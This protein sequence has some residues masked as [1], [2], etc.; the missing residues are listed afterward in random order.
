MNGYVISIDQSTQ[1]TKAIL[2]DE[3]GNLIKRV[4]KKHKQIINELGYV[5]H[6]PIEIYQN[7]ILAVTELISVT[8][9]DKNLIRAL[10]ISNQRETTVMWDDQGKPYENAVV[11]SYYMSL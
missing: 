11:W 4:D 7:T 6:D 8:G 1:S 5:S 9:I 10:G 3:K 2:F